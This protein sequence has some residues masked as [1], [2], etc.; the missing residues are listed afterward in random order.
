MLK[1]GSKAT[2]FTVDFDASNMLAN[3][4]VETISEIKRKRTFWKVND[5][6]LGGVNKNF[7]GKKVEPKFFNIDFFASTELGS[8]FLEFGNPEKISGEML[9]FTSF[10][11]FG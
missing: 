5:V 9:N 3:F 1:L 7:V 2:H 6:A 10:V 11:I 4:R 8:G